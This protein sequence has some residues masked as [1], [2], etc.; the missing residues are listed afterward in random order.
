MLGGRRRLPAIPSIASFNVVTLWNAYLRF[1]NP[2]LSDIIRITALIIT[3]ARPARRIYLSSA[4]G[5]TQEEAVFS[6]V[7]VRCTFD[8]D[9]TDHVHL[10]Q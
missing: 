10:E 2:K 8:L 4:F 5:W 3:A 7:A 6:C 1:P 9:M